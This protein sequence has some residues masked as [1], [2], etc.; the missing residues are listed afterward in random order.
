[1]GPRLLLNDS[2]YYSA[3][4]IQLAHGTFFREVFVD[5]PGAE[6]GPLT[7]TLLAL[8]S[9]VDAP[10]PWQRLMTALFG[11]ASVALIGL[12]ARAVAGGRVGL[13]A[14][15][16]AAAYPNLW[17]NDGLVMSESLSILLVTATLLAAVTVLARPT[18]PVR[19][20]SARSRIRRARPERARPPRA[21]ARA[22]RVAD[23]AAL[24]RERAACS[25]VLPALIVAGALVVMAP[26]VT[27]NVAR[28]ERPVTLTTNDGTTL[29]GAYCDETF[30]GPYRGGWS[31][32]C[33]VNDPLYRVD[34][35]PS[36]RSARQRSLARDYAMD[37]L[38]ELPGSWSRGSPARSTCT[39]SATSCTRTWG[40]S[41]TAGRRGRASCRG[42]CSPHWR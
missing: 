21:R 8:V 15:A 5:Q 28:F 12:L 13:V 16:I 22:A 18:R 9:W 34:E 29:L 38:R 25:S 20:H 24:A 35:E 39:T 26:W 17:M 10:T 30:S 36:V 37:H 40:R 3:Q 6:H 14:T 42:G 11:V 4:A 2:L 32:G 31:L 1:V 7:S 27:F 41:G 19:R 23:P 33:V